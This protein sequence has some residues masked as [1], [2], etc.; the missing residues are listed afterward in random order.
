MVT[1]VSH[2]AEFVLKA[3]FQVVYTV[4]I[5]IYIYVYLYN[6]YIIYTHR[7]SGS[8]VFLLRTWLKRVGTCVKKPALGGDL[9][10]H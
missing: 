8:E 4:H 9:D 2:Q 5:Y 3:S 1:S 7:W 6:L 10:Q